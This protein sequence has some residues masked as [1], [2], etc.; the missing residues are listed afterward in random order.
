MRRVF[1]PEDFKGEVKAVGRHLGS[2]MGGF[3]GLPRGYVVLASGERVEV[4]FYHDDSDLEGPFFER[5]EP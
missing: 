4:D 2:G 5:I 1:Y 3:E